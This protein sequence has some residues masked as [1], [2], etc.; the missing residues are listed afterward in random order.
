[1]TTSEPTL[2]FQSTLPAGEA[3][4]QAAELHHGRHNFNPRFPRGKRPTF[5]F[6]ELE[7]LLFQSTL[8]AGEATHKFLLVNDFILFQSTLPAGEA[9]QATFTI[10]LKPLAFQS[11]LPAG[12]ATNFYGGQQRHKLHFNP[13]FPRGKRLTCPGVCPIFVYFNP[14]F[15]RGKR[16]F[17]S[18]P[19][20]HPAG[21]SIHASRGGSDYNAIFRAA[22][23]L[24]FNPRFPR[25]KRHLTELKAD[26]GQKQF[27]STLPAGEATHQAR[28]LSLCLRNF[29][30]RFP[31]GKRPGSGSL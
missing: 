25:G 5:T 3:T 2:R 24:D 10:L 29:N 8:P 26:S 30:P 11:T 18:A 17:R 9:T 14:R 23:R 15:P 6:Q 13:R 7:D 28:I 22:D 16:H 1:M 12:E 27:Q 21:I 31:R 19:V 4:Q 20:S